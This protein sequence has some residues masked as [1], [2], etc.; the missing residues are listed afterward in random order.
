[1]NTN[2]APFAD[3]CL[4]HWVERVRN[5]AV[6]HRPLRLRG[7]GSK[8]FYGQSLAGELF[9]TREYAGLVAYEPTEL[10]VTARCG[11]PLAELEA[12]LADQGQALA[13]EPP[14]F[15]PNATVGGCVASGLAGPRR[16]KAG[17]V[18][19]FVLGVR[20]L[21]GHGHVLNFGGQV[22]KNVA[23]YDVPRLL[24]GSLGTLGLI[25][26]VSLK[27]MPLALTEK[28]LRFELAQD[29]AL[30]VL[31][32]WGGLPLPV[33]ASAWVE[34]VLSVRL[35][36]SPTAVNAAASKLGGDPVVTDEASAFWLS[37][38]EQ[39]H[40]FFTSSTALWRVAVP[41]T[42]AVLDLPGTQLVEWGGVQRWLHAEIIEDSQR[43]RRVATQAG[44]HA[45]LFRADATEKAA[46]GVFHPL[47]EPL[48]RIH[49]R[50]KSAF[51]APGIFNPGRM[52]SEF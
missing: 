27:V 35:S 49:L 26:E 25:L 4:A 37:L 33:S 9:D 1:M 40:T 8:D 16:A 52:Y 11:T 6:E 47:T 46:I 2:V 30:A 32:Q 3:P 43:I 17:A 50:L 14:H 28:T 10:V 41:S 29:K 44:G 31:N 13:F 7:S 42:S 12:T 19:D 22:M 5:A 34:N 20:M 48:A 36:G 18:R 38:R 45:T 21:D 15:G 23:G 39:S 51:D 24:A